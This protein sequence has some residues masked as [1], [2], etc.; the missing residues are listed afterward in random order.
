MDATA[1]QGRDVQT[2]RPARPRP[3]DLA[4]VARLAGG[5]ASAG[6]VRVT[7]VCLDSAGR[8]SRCWPG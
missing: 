8:R 2:L 3:L 7:G 4:E 5:A 6:G 1:Q